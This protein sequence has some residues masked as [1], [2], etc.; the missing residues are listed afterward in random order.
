MFYRHYPPTPRLAPFVASM[1]LYRNDPQPRV[2]MLPSGTA[3]VVIDLSGGGMTL[4]P[5]GPLFTTHSR[6]AYATILHGVD[7]TAFSHESDRP[8]YR[9][10][11][12]FRPGG[13]YPFF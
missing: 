9:F 8:L 5:S 10:G 6:G 7:S 1:W 12:D 4:P 2:R 13:L 3:Q 11:V